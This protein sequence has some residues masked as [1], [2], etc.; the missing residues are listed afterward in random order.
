M[1]YRLG[2]NL[3]ENKFAEKDLGIRVEQPN[4]A[5]NTALVIKAAKS[6]WGDPSP[7][8]HWG[9]SAAGLGTAGLPSTHRH[10]GTSPAS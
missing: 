7:A 2:A 5:N 1:P 6:P 10:I 3:L 4:G 8:Q 9:G